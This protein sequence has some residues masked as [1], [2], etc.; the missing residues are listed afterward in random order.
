[1]KEL[2]RQAMADKTMALKEFEHWVLF[3]PLLVRLTRRLGYEFKDPVYLF[4]AICHD[5]FVHEYPRWKLSSNERLEFLGDAVI[6]VLVSEMIF[7]ER[8][9]FHEGELSKLRNALINESS[10]ASLAR[11]MDL[12]Q[13][14]LLGRGEIKSRGMEKDSLLSDLFEAL[15]GAVFYDG[16]FESS[17]RVFNNILSH[18]ET[19]FG[20][21][22]SDPCCLKD[23]DPKSR[24]QE[25]TMATYGNFPLYR[26]IK[27]DR[28]GFEMEL[29]ISGESMGKARASSKK[30]AEEILAKEAWSRLG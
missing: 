6:E 30:K 23:F 12:G 3:H 9:L 29:V 28:D 1:M 7:K 4:R 18:Y 10:L 17:R 16:G 20:R 15:M 26:V 25:W 13:V 5:S 2:S 8:P 22:F 24:L 21:V 11:L 19:T 27:K 14:I